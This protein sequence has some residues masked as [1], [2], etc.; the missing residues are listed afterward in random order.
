ME[1]SFER[2]RD[3]IEEFVDRTGSYFRQ[4]DEQERY[5]WVAEG[6]GFLTFIV[7][8]VLWIL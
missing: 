6:G 3:A 7:G 8:I 5:G 4:L 2:M 1:L